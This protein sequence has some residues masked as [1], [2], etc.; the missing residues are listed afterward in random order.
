M[1]K[2]VLALDPKTYR[3]HPIHSEGRM[4]A[5]TNCYADVWI[6]LAH[7][8]GYEP[9]AA[10]PSTFAIDFEGDQWTFF[11]FPLEDL[12]ELFGLHVQELLIWGPLAARLEEQIG[13]GCP[14]LVE[15]DSFYLPDT[16][17]SSYRMAHVKTTVGAVEI[18]IDQK[19]LGYFHAQ[20]YYHLQGDDFLDALRLR[21]PQDPAML[22]PYAEFV[23]IRN[24]ANGNGRDLVAKSLTLLKK[25]LGLAPSANPFLRFKT[26]FEQDIG[27]LLQESLDAFHQYSFATLRQYGA[28]YELS[29]TYLQWLAAQGEQGLEDMTRAFLALSE[30]A[31]AFQFQLA[32]AMARR[33][34][35]DL[36]P[37]D[38]M[39]EQWEQGMSGLRAR[40]G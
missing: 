34:S 29:A 24:D 40:Y 15:L 36:L 37:L 39:A 1:T 12:Y 18:D 22:P 2:R 38:S 20:G 9:N 14:V 27:G 3:R 11:K 5:E 13:R 16:T 25:H 32:R 7:A 17:G 19:H 21:E 26:R 8:L 6:E 35:L 31:K 30:G 23:K 10:L 4:W 28:C 33:R